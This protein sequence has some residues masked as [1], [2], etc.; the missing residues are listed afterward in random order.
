MSS[1]RKTNQNHGLQVNFMFSGKLKICNPY[2]GIFMPYFGQFPF[3][4]ESENTQNHKNL[5]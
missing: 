2:L 1:F 3:N 5:D 4:R